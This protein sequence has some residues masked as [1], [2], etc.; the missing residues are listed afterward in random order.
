MSSIK[1]DTPPGDARFPGMNQN[2]RCWVNFNEYLI[3]M[4]ANG[5][6]E[7]KCQQR[8]KT[9]RSICPAEWVENWKEQIEE[10]TFPGVT[11]GNA[12]EEHH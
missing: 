8:L 1:F 7:S 6:D 4:N 2:H 12:T 5:D 3:C 10:N 9:Y 11:F